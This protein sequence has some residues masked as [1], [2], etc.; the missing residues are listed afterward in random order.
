V[1]DDAPPVVVEA[2]ELTKRFGDFTAVDSLNLQ[3]REGEIFG[4]LGSN[5]AGKTTAIR[6]FC[7]LQRPTGGD[8]SVLGIDVREDP[9]AIKRRIGYMSQRFSLY[10]DLTVAQNLRF[11]GGVYGLRGAR[12]RDRERWALETTGLEDKQD[13]VTGSLPGGWKQRLALASAL[14]HEPPLVFLDEPT[15]SVDPISR[16]DF[17]RLIRDLA[18]RGTTV[19]VTTHYLDEAEHC[20]RL[21]LMHAGKLVA[22]GTVSELKDVFADRG[23]LEIGCPRVV[24][25]MEELGKQDW[26]TETSIFGTRIHLVVDDPEEGRRRALELLQEADNTPATVASIVP[27]LEDVFIHHIEAQSGPAPGRPDESGGTRP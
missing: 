8:A 9:E 20:H 14:L 25:A 2:V 18:D 6:M 13:L 27:S 23:V 11:Y 5:G 22:V 3:V 4:F 12:L 24:E 26:V 16:R 19:F 17:W 1:N 10:E 7:G 15:G 21:A